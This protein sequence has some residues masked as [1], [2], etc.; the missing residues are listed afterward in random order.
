M[1]PRRGGFEQRSATLATY[2]DARSRSRDVHACALRCARPPRWCFTSLERADARIYG[3]SGADGARALPSCGRS[4]SAYRAMTVPQHLGHP[5]LTY[6][7][8]C[9]GVT[10][11]TRPQSWQTS[12]C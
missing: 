1:K 9:S 8:C 7:N 3:D 10:G 5:W 12:T 6:F 11:R 4:T 2:P